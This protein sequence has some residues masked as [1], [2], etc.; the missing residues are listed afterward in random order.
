MDLVNLTIFIGFATGG[1][2]LTLGLKKEDKKY[3]FLS[4]LIALIVVIVAFTRA[5][6]IINAR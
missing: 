2:A 6:N 1:T 3:I 5:T 4:I